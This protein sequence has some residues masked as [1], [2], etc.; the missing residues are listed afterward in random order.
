MSKVFGAFLWLKQN[1]QQP[2][3]MASLAAICAMLGV[4][5]DPGMIQHIINILTIFFGALGFWLQP[6][7]QVAKVD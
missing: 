6:A 1:L 2:S 7:K 4:Q 5:V 3:T